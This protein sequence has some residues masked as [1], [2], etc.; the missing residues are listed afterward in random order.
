MSWKNNTIFDIN[1]STR[2]KN[3][4]I[5]TGYISEAGLLNSTFLTPALED[6]FIL[7]VWKWSLLVVQLKSGFNAQQTHLKLTAAMR[8]HKEVVR[9]LQ[10][11]TFFRYGHKNEVLAFQRMRALRIVEHDYLQRQRFINSS[12][13]FNVFVI[14]QKH[15]HINITPLSPK[16]S[17]SKSF[18]SLHVLKDNFVPK[19]N[20]LPAKHMNKI[21]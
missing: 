12:Q 6:F 18:N 10:K 9:F 2:K 1:I 21:M 14:A 3:F 16:K 8:Y 19:Q 7:D 20:M 15:L 4:L 11:M 17:N 13:I 5:S